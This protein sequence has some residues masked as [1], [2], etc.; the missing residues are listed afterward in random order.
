MVEDVD[1]QYETLKA[2]FLA[3]GKG[4]WSNL[5]CDIQMDNRLLIQL[6]FLREE[7]DKSWREVESWF[8]RLCPTRS[9]FSSKVRSLVESAMKKF[10]ACDVADADQYLNVQLKLDLIFSSLSAVGVTR[11]NIFDEA[12]CQLVK[13]DNIT[14]QK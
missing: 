7:G 9:S 4:R 13:P 10:S 14:N 3:S 1:G 12:V 6:F 2:V 8:L 5:P 11:D